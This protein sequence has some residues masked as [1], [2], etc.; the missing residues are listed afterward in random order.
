MECGPFTVTA[1]TPFVSDIPY[2]LKHH[3][4]FLGVGVVE[5]HDELA[6]PADLVVLIQQRC[7]RMSNVQVPEVT[8]TTKTLEIHCD[9]QLKAATE[10]HLPR[11]LGREPGDHLSHLRSGEVHKLP[12]HAPLR[13]GHASSR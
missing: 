2:L 13:W 5:P 4:L 9:Q 10:P 12:T 11:G 6:L 7:L 3:I 1:A 8:M